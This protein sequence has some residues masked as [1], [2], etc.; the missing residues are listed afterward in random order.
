MCATCMLCTMYTMR[1]MCTLNGMSQGCAKHIPMRDSTPTTIS[2]PH[3]KPAPS[4][5][6]HLS[7]PPPPPQAPPHSQSMLSCTWNN[8]KQIWFPLHV[9]TPTRKSNLINHITRFIIARFVIMLFYW[10]RN[11]QTN[12]LS[13]SVDLKPH[14]CIDAKPISQRHARDGVCSF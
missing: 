2:P 11:L 4:P 14:I 7:P 8:F 5:T 1:T 12:T 10:L 9:I 3:S 6:T 13:C